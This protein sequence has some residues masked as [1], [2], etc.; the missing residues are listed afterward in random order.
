MGQQIDLCG[1]E[2]RSR[3]HQRQRVRLIDQPRPAQALS[4]AGRHVTEYLFGPAYG[5]RQRAR[6]SLLFA[7]TDERTDIAIMRNL[8]NDTLPELRVLDSLADRKSV[9]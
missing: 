6:R 1:G 8:D 3:L 9:V 2:S 4:R 5:R 7:N